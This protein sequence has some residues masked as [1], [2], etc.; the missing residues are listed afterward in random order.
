MS[1]AATKPQARALI[2]ILIACIMLTHAMINN[3]QHSAND[4]KHYDN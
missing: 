2:L 3:S 4:H 1:K